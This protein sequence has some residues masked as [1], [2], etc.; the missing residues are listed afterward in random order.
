MFFISSFRSK[1]HEA[2]DKKDYPYWSSYP[3]YKSERNYG[4]P[5]FKQEKD[6][7]NNNYFDYDDIGPNYVRSKFNDNY[8]KE[9]HERAD[10]VYSFADYS[11]SE[12]EYNYDVYDD[13]VREDKINHCLFL[14]FSITFTECKNFQEIKFICVNLLAAIIVFY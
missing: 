6:P 7:N 2:S 10:P 5:K 9:N 4:S 13:E 1:W 12:D 14:I 8:L 11:P 3:E